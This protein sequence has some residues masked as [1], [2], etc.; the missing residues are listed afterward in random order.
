MGPVLQLCDLAKRCQDLA[1]TN[2]CLRR[3]QEEVRRR[4]GGRPLIIHVLKL[5][6]QFQLHAP[7]VWW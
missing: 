6:E 2:C 3:T 7:R 4:G 1:E 5:V